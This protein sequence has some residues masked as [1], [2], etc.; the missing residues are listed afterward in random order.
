M[1]SAALTPELDSMALFRAALPE[2]ARDA[3]IADRLCAIGQYRRLAAGDAL[4]GNPREDRLVFIASGVTK[5][6][7]QLPPAPGDDA[8]NAGHKTKVLCK[9]QVLA[10]HFPGDIVSVLRKEDGDLRIV[11]LKDTQLIVFFADQFLDIAQDNPAV[12]RSTLASSIQALH[13]SRT[14]MMQLGHKSAGHRIAEF[15]T[16]MAQRLCGCT[17]GR[18]EFVLPMSRRD[19]ADSLGLTIE[20]VSRQFAELREIGLIETQGR[21]IVRVNQL[22][23]LARRGG[24]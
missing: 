17:K 11:A 1:A 16:S 6:V 24:V 18:C 21:S 9:N 19:I 23:T 15:L 3:V 12:I 8:Q 2:C 13:A 10:F 14:R 4:P 5:L 20:T 7:A 22:D